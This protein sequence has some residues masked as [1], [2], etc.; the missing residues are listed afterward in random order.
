MLTAAVAQGIRINAVCPGIIQTPMLDKM[1]AT[2]ADALD[3][4]LTPSQKTSW[5]SCITEKSQFQ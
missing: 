5:R 1:L 4:S 3:V 2:Q